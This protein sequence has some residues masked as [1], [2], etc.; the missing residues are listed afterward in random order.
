MKYLFVVLALFSVAAYADYYVC[1]CAAGADGDCVQGNDANDGLSAANAF[2]TY[3]QARTTYNAMDCSTHN[4]YFCKGGAWE[5]A[6]TVNEWNNTGMANDYCAVSSYSASWATGDEDRPYLKYTLTD[7]SGGLF[8][9]NN[10]LSAFQEFKGLKLECSSAG[11]N[12]AA[13]QS[14]VDTNHLK[15]T[16]LEIFGCRDGINVGGQPHIE[17][18][19]LYVYDNA[20][21][22]IWGDFPGLDANTKSYIRNS[23][24]NNNGHGNGSNQANNAHIELAG[25][26]T[27]QHVIIEK[28]TFTNAG[29]SSG[30]CAGPSIFMEDTV[31]NFEI[32]SNSIRSSGTPTSEC[33][34]IKTD[35]IANYTDIIISRNNIIGFGNYAVELVGCSGNCVIE[36]NLAINTGAHTSS[37]V[38]YTSGNGSTTDRYNRAIFRS[39]STAVGQL[40][41]TE[42]ATIESPEVVF[43]GTAGS[44]SGCFN[45]ASNATVIGELQ[46]FEGGDKKAVYKATWDDHPPG[47]TVTSYTLQASVN[48]GAYA[49]V[50]P[51]ILD[52]GA[53]GAVYDQLLLNA[54]DG[55]E[56][57]VRV[58]ATNDAG[59]SPNSP[60]VCV[61]VP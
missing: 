59:N 49:S 25:N 45:I 23:V 52:I 38:F 57:C 50:S 60:T 37:A 43:L 21:D 33:Q 18:S 22:G 26:T 54:D 14:T 48:S 28:N 31:S 8:V 13:V 41:T 4:M 36:Y 7:E 55:D 39:G 42:S 2:E 15:L 35:G 16:D 19:S 56:I 3:E 17:F 47:E 40:I 30:N 58:F 10:A 32:S 5:V 51:A 29:L 53:P 34:P 6:S 9:V 46:C 24:F 11:Y 12:G 20:S 44:S 1:D 27:N 61:N